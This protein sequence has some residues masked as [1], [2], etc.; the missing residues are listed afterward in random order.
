MSITLESLLAKAQ[1]IQ[2]DPRRFAKYYDDPEGFVH[3]VLGINLWQKQIDVLNAVAN[4]NRIAVRSG[5]G[6]GK[7]FVTAC[8]VLWWL[9]ARQG[10]VVTTAP[11][12]EHVSMVL[13]QEIN[14]LAERALAPLPGKTLQT[15]RV[16]ETQWYAVG[17]STNMP[18]AFQ[19]RHHPRLLVVVD[20]APGVSELIHLE[21]STLATGEQNCI[22]MIGNPTT[23]SGTF[24]EAF[25]A[26][27]IWT[28]LRIN[29]L[30]HP[31]VVS[32]KEIIPGATTRGWV[33]ERRRMWGEHHPF[34]YSRVLGDFPKI[35]SKGVVPLGWCERA[36][37]EELR[38]R[39]LAEATEQRIPRV[40]GLDVARY[41]DNQ[42]VLTIRR[43]DAIEFQEAWSHS[44]IT[45]T[46]GRAMLAIKDYDLKLLVIDAAGVGAGVFDRLL[47]LRAPV[48]GYNGGHRA[49]TPGSFS[50]RRSE[51][52]WALRTRLE[53]QRLWLP[54]N[55]E[56][57]VAELV[58]PEYELT[59]S[60][61][62]KV[63]TKEALLERGIKSPDFADS[64]ILCFSMDEN[65][66]ADLVPALGR[67]QDPWIRED[68]QREE[69][70]TFDQLG[71]GF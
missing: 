27:D 39:A 8:T 18:G 60:G 25:K 54:T 62:I 53:K 3:E 11:T 19:G 56:K 31:N 37:N 30:D 63:E 71:A 6:T 15:E 48:Q 43:G 17:L 67:H 24:Y 44:S 2:G 65:P 16:V 32:G 10:V 21:I 45:E 29:C 52:W 70:H 69:D 26:P 64:L 68:F 51:M 14:G 5:H 36:Q 1:E 61:R 13:W 20:E 28:C 66:E 33:E 23:L 12:W 38:L 34:W 46:C 4:N 50:N 47:E 55:S 58:T 42:C 49:F 57:L 7:T 35:S 9:Y 40:G 59:S 41:G 22:L